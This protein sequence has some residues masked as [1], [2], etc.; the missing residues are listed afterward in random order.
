MVE[1][2]A[3]IEPGASYDGIPCQSVRDAILTCRKR[4]LPERLTMAA[5][6]ALRQG[7]ID[8]EGHR[9]LKERLEAAD[10]G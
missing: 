2:I 3:G 5:D 10:G 4:M 9:D 6:E 7:L 8:D 1:H